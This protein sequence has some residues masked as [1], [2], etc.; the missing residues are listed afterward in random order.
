MFTIAE[1]AD[2]TDWI[3]AQALLYDYVEW[4]RAASGFDPF[5]KQDEFGPE[6]EQLEELYSSHDRTL[7][8]AWY[9]ELAVGTV[10]MR[11]HIDDSVELKRMY[12]RP[13]ARGRGIADRLIDA[14]VGAAQVERQRSVW[15]E[16]LRGVM[17]PALAVYRRHGFVETNRHRTSL[18][19][20]GLVVMERTLAD[21]DLPAQN[22]QADRACA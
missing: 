17:E 13:I 8:V 7:F 5:E 21:A 22:G 19:V 10:G 6:I 12:V 18:S 9:G 16:S 3:Q 14:V 2:A 4:I 15:L 11:R 1:A 20:P